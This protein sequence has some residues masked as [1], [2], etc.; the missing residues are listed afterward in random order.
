MFK[1][2]PTRDKYQRKYEKELQTLLEQ[3]ISQVD[4]KIKRSLA[5]IDLPTGGG[6]EGPQVNMPEMSAFQQEAT[7][8]RIDQLEQK[9][10][11]YIE[12]AEKLGEEGKIEESEA[13]MKEVDK[14]KI[15]KSELEALNDPVLAAQAKM[16]RNAMKVC[17]VCGGLQ[18]AADT[19]KRM[20]MHVEG[21]LHTGYAKI[22][23]VLTELKAKRDEYRRQNDRQ[24]GRRSRSRSLSPSSKNRNSLKPDPKQEKVEESF[25]YSSKKL[26]TGANCHETTS[27]RFSDY[28]IQ[29]NTESNE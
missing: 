2:D 25:L 22:R 16:D 26:G 17:E 6:G 8:Q 14:L 21:K 11:F 23:K 10:N 27:I 18:T 1:N 29:M 20:V 28:A 7:N 19:D 13:V 15:Q 4:Q 5:R 9:I 3:M 24:G 12:K